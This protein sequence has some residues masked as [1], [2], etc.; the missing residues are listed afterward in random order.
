MWKNE[1]NYTYPKSFP[2]FFIDSDSFLKEKQ[3]SFEC[4]NKR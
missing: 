1:K 4:F 2:V 3:N